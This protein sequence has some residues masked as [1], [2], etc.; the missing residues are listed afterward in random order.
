[1]VDS[2]I[3]EHRHLTGCCFDDE[4]KGVPWCFHK[5]EI[6]VEQPLSRLV[7]FTITQNQFCPRLEGINEHGIMSECT[8]GFRVGSICSLKCSNQISEM[9]DTFKFH[10]KNI[11]DK[12]MWLEEKDR[13]RKPECD[14]MFSFFRFKNSKKKKLKFIFGLVIMPVTPK[15]SRAYNYI[16][17]R[18]QLFG[19][20]KLKKGTTLKPLLHAT[21]SFRTIFLL[22][23][24][25][26][27]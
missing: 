20:Q 17:S 4:V 15:T 8:D 16:S 27:T 19:M 22:I 18:L 12:M 21:F 3:N 7:K 9:G 26:P 5:K 2:I 6:E 13:N 10:C 25:K 11:D 1:M 23:F 24:L 14:G